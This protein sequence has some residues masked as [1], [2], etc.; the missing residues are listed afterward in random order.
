MHTWNLLVYNIVWQ[1]SLK[2]IFAFLKRK[3]LYFLRLLSH[4]LKH[5]LLV[6]R[7]YSRQTWL[8]NARQHLSQ[9]IFFFL[10]HFDLRPCYCFRR[11]KSLEALTWIAVK[12]WGTQCSFYEHNQLLCHLSHS[13]YIL[14]NVNCYYNFAP[15]L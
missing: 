4:Q 5:P 2:N 13:F 8:W 15:S 9:L 14:L 11:S 10:S 3:Y 1:L 6:S 12:I 7:Y